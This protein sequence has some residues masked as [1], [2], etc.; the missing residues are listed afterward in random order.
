MNPWN[1]WLLILLSGAAF[2]IPAGARAALTAEQVFAA[3]KPDVRKQLLAGEII[4][5]ARPEQETSDSGLAVSLAVIVPAD[6]NKTV[7]TFRSL[8]VKDDA[9]QRRTTR[10][11]NGIVRGDGSSPAFAT[12]GFAADE[13]EEVKK[14]LRAEPG[15]DFNFSKEELAWIGQAAASGADPAQAATGVM[16]RVLESRYLAYRKA[17]L[18]ELP[19]YARRDGKQVNPGAELAATT[20]AMPLLRKDL[21]DFYQAYRNYPKAGPAGLRHSFYWDKKTAEGRPMFSL[22]HEIVQ[23]KPDS[24]NIANREFYISNS[25]NT[26][27][28][29]IALLPHGAHTLVV[30]AN[31][32]Y[33]D[34][35]SGAGRLVA[36]RVGR[37]IVESNTKPLLEKLQKALGK[38]LPN[39]R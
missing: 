31:Q 29:A 12:I 20:E 25:L 2:V 18:A 24:A 32:T 5:L 21:P 7:S 22:R 6:L 3:L 36:V 19:P 33:T 1:R 39:T 8:N 26:L 23:I 11:I 13:K 28:V 34:K 17:G 35:V 37:S 15:D 10:E 14:M 27:Q 16:R 30:M 4:T 9:K 38:A